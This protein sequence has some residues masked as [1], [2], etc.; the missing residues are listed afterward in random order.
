MV[1]RARR[2]AH[3]FTSRLRPP[4]CARS[5]RG[6]R[7]SGDGA[8]GAGSTSRSTRTGAEDARPRSSIVV[9]LG[10][11][12]G[13]QTRDG[14]GAFGPEGDGSLRKYRAHAVVA[15]ERSRR[16]QDRVA[17]ASL[18]NVT[19]ALG[20]APGTYDVLDRPAGSP[21]S[22][23][24]SSTNSSRDT[25]G[26]RGEWTRRD[27]W[28]D[29]DA[30]GRAVRSAVSCNISAGSGPGAESF[31]RSKGRL[32]LDLRLA[33][34][35]L[36]SSRSPTSLVVSCPPLSSSRSPPSRHLVPPLG[37]SPRSPRS[38]VETSSSPRRAR[39]RVPCPP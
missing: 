32:A 23:D 24:R 7:R 26:T 25:T 20:V 10:V 11:R 27:G 19:D 17:I 16:Q 36:S 30:V 6:R 8:D 28:I 29:R 4:G 9:S 15:N 21:T 2:V 18:E 31:V 14:P 38:R 34:T 3:F 35:P 1:I 22:S 39:S 12:G 13:F 37:A 33:T 5:N